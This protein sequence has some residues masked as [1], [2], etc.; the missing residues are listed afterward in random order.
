VLRS[1]L[2]ELDLSSENTD[3]GTLQS[4]FKLPNDHNSVRMS[5]AF[6]NAVFVS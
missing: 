2:A 1:I 4:N 5:L 6:F 3:E